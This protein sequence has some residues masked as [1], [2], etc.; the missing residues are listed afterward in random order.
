MKFKYISIALLGAV[1]FGVWFLK[2]SNTQQQRHDVL[3]IGI[4]ADYAPYLSINHNGEYEGFDIDVA[5]A[6]A[7]AMGKELVLKD[8]GSMPS[9]FMA[10]DQGFVDALLWGI[11]ITKDRTEKV[12]F[13][14]YHGNTTTSFPLIFWGKIPAGVTSLA[15]MKGATVCVEPASA[16]SSVLTNYEDILTIIPTERVDDAFLAIQQG[17]ADAALVD[18]AIAKKFKSRYPEIQILEIPLVEEDQ[19]FGMGIPVKKNNN[20]LKQAISSAVDQLKSSGVIK[21]LEEKWDVA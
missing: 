4:A 5:Y 11:S 20:D 12:D 1:I 21:Q 10:L 7:G 9:L 14:P 15:D 2:T 8:L 6:L 13:V 3:V 17:K 18:P 19:V 16:Q